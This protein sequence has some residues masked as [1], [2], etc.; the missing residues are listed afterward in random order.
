L[1]GFL[2]QYLAPLGALRW[3]AAI[4]AIA[5][6]AVMVACVFV[7]DEDKS[8][9]SIPGLKASTRG[10]LSALQRRQLWIIALF[11][12]FFYFSPGIDTP[13]YF[14]M[15]DHLKFGQAYIGVLSAINAAGGIAA[16]LFYSRFLQH[17]SAKSLLN[18]S[19]LVGVLGTLT[20][21]FL[22]DP[23]T[24]AVAH[25]CYGAASMITLVATLGMAADHCPA[26]SEGF[27]FAALVS[28]TNIGGSLADNVGS[29]L[30]ERVFHD[31]IYPLILV[32]AAFTALNFVLV[33]FLQLD[34]EAPSP[35]VPLRK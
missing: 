28:V 6:V 27:A 13:L 23:A 25:F 33:P 1:G 9:I 21:L 22:L 24:A 30:Y 26:G 32:A 34:G 12:L 10:L 2:I 18:L 14:Y 7:V 20:F 29:F 17:I 8:T 31:G 4:A 11:L 19:I 35:P 3:A 16:A 5:P 15:T